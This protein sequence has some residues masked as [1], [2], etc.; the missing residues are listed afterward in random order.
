MN[1]ALR[2]HRR[3]EP[4]R[5]RRDAIGCMQQAKSGFDRHHG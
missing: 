1:A 3:S 2:L 4:S 5:I